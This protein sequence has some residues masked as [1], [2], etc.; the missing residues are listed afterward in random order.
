MALNR[1]VLKIDFGDNLVLG[2]TAIEQSG[3]KGLVEKA[4]ETPSK[5]F[6]L[7]LILI[8]KR[9]FNLFFTVPVFKGD[10]RTISCD[11]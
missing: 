6:A 9:H 3:F 2:L 11:K 5:N 4:F 1:E 7:H 10:N 8:C